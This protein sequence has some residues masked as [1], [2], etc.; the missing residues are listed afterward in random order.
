MTFDHALP[1]P[2]PWLL[3]FSAA[4][5]TELTEGA[6]RTAELLAGGARPDELRPFSVRPGPERLAVAAADAA[7][8]A[9]GLACFAGGL[10]SP[11]WTAGRA[12]GAAG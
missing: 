5:R 4:T 11:R 9:E 2:P 7:G 3:L 10:P 12:D 1:P 8:L 6:K